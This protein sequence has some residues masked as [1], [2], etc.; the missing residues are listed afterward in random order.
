[1]K[2]IFLVIALA[3]AI[4]TQTA[5]VLAQSN[6]AHSTS[7]PANGSVGAT[8][9]ETAAKTDKTEAAKTEKTESEKTDEAHRTQPAPA[10]PASAPAAAPSAS[11]TTAAVTIAPSTASTGVEQST[12][13]APTKIIVT[14]LGA[15]PVMTPAPKPQS[16]AA[17]VTTAATTGSTTASAAPLVLTN[18]YRVG[19]GDVLDIRLLNANTSES[20]LF[21]ILEGGLLEYPLAGDQLPVTG[22]TVEEIGA[23]LQSRV[24]IYDKPQVVVS[25]REYSSH[26]VI[27][28]GLVQEPG[29]KILRR[30]AVPLYVLLA[31]AQPRPEAG[32]ATIMRNGSQGITVD[33]NDTTATAQLIYPGDVITLTA[34]PA[35]A[36]QYYFIG[37]QIVSPGQKDFHAGLTLTQAILACGG[38][39]RFAGS[40]V[41]VS[42]QGADG[43]L[44]TT[45]Y[46]LKQIE[47]GKIPDPL[48]QPGDRVEIGR[49]GW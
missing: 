26:N 36:P 30:E 12:T 47:S 34:T 39:G 4:A 17:A 3:L 6:D 29:T 38:V 46:N 31:Q 40:K 28:T 41:K 13:D 43:R 25:V 7:P 32:R 11:P 21:T 48:L 35:P 24:K 5:V 45:E 14:G 37:G 23:R 8:A 16:P 19:V 33:L 22:L 42:R 10:A 18:I 1:M 27:V 2:R 20:T 49:S 9:N 15:P 44:M